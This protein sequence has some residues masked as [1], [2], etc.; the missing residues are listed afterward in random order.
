MTNYHIEKIL[1]QNIF[2]IAP[3]LRERESYSP[4]SKKIDLTSFLQMSIK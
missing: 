4:L 2:T 1:I 3:E